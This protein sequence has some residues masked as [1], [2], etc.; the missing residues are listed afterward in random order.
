MNELKIIWSS[1]VSLN[2]DAISKLGT[3]KG[4]YRLSYLDDDTNVYVFFVGKNND[5]KS[6]LLN[7]I[8]D[9]ETNICIKN[10]ANKKRYFKYADLS[11]FDET[12][13]DQ[14][15]KQVCKFYRPS[16]NSDVIVRD[17]IITI[18]MN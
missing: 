17:D 16:C 13:L 1:L 7:H 18:N 2:T 11:A 15:Y 3:I 6:Q 8:S 10:L 12:I 4:V 14:V 5:I 9:S